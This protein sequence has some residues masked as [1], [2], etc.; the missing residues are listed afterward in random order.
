MVSLHVNNLDIILI[1]WF[2]FF[3]REIF[4]DKE[5]LRVMGPR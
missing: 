2:N 3:L 1:F 5:T 4:H